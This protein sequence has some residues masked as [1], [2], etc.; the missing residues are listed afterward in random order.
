MNASRRPAPRLTKRGSFIPG[1]P[2]YNLL[3]TT[4]SESAIYHNIYVLMD[5]P[6]DISDSSDW[7]QTPLFQLGHV[8]QAMRCQVCKDFFD[9]P[10]ITSCSHT[11]CSLCIRRCLTTDGR[12]PACRTQDQAVKLRVNST[13]QQL[14]DAFKSA[15]SV[16]L[17]FGQTAEERVAQSKKRKIGHT[18]IEED[19]YEAQKLN[20]G[21]LRRTKTRSTSR[22]HSISY[23]VDS[24]DDHFQSGQC[25][26][27]LALRG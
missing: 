5:T 26:R 7:S 1:S 10:M 11:F 15:R 24:N 22:R 18:G 9:T 14:V 27:S 13:V 25:A 3:D 6:F 8:E 4:A 16:V 17:Q 19:D 2:G 20:D 21:I 23:A 12:C